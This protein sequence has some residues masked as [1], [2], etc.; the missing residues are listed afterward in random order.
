MTFK[1][2][3]GCAANYLS[4]LLQSYVPTLLAFCDTRCSSCSHIL[5]PHIRDRAFLVALPNLRTIYQQILEHASAIRFFE[6]AVQDP[7]LLGHIPVAFVVGLP[8]KHFFS[9]VDCNLRPC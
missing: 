3:N 7:S 9:Y 6:K 8:L 2:T 1:I 4:D 5:Y